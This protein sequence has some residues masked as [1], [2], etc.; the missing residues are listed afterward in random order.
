MQQ[1][2]RVIEIVWLIFAIGSLIYALYMINLLGFN[3]AY[4]YFIPTGIATL[5]YI[6][7]RTIR[8]RM[9]RK[10]NQNRK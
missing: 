9:E 3:I 6:F 8:K 2:G 4:I 7:R 1:Y 10:Q 5:A